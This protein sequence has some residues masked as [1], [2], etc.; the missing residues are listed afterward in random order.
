MGGMGGEGEG[1]EGKERGRKRGERRMYCT[2]SIHMAMH[3]VC[4]L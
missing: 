4:I 3:V 2:T 1:K